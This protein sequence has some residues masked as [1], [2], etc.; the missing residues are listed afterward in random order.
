MH[1]CRAY[2]SVGRQTHTGQTS[3]WMAPAVVSGAKVIKTRERTECWVWGT[4][5]H[6]SWISQ[7]CHQED[8]IYVNVCRK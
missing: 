4:G 7:R 6:F 5:C 3:E 2:S 8:G 1:P